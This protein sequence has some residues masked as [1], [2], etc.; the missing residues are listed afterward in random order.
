MTVIAYIIASIMVGAAL[1]TITTITIQDTLSV[2]RQKSQRKSKRGRMPAQTLT[3]P[4]PIPTTM[5][6]LF[7][8]YRHIASAPF[9]SVR[10][11]FGINHRSKHRRTTRRANPI[12][13]TWR[14]MIYAVARW[15]SA[16][17]N[18]ITLGYACYVAVVLYQQ[19]YLQAYLLCFSS[20]I[21]FATWR[22][23]YLTF[24]QRLA[25]TLLA[26]VTYGY[27]FLLALYAPITHLVRRIHIVIAAPALRSTLLSS[28]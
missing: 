28:A 21:I 10:Q 15:L 12:A 7:H 19:I 4:L 3:K 24:K 9:E 1:L 20:W 8:N 25:Y 22:Y 11:G 5:R 2:R 6:Q 13:P 18:A 17:A 26:P 14:E 23:P 27:F 16:S